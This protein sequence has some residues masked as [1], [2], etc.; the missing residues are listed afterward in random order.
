MK[1]L[2]Y[3]CLARFF[4]S[5]F[6]RV[7]K[8]HILPEDVPYGLVTVA[9]IGK[10]LGMDTPKMDAIANI[11]FMANGAD[12]WS[13]GRTAKKLGLTGMSVSQMVEYAVK[14][15]TPSA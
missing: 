7:G 8:R 2:I 6:I 3:R 12:Y 13:T 1:K 14:E 11:A 5:D 10:L 9:T 15:P 4:T